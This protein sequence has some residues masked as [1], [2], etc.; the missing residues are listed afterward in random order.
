MQK[1]H[2][3][4]LV[5]AFLIL[6][7]SAWAACRDHDLEGTYD[8][9]AESSGA[10]GTVTTTCEIAV[11]RNG[12]VQGGA[13]CKL[14]NYGVEAVARVDGGEISISRSCRVTGQIVFDGYP[15]VITKARMS[16]DKNRVTGAGTNA[17]D[18]SPLTFTAT[19][20][21]AVKSKNPQRSGK[22]K[23]RWWRWFLH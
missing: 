21:V 5:V 17:L 16:R 14:S 15:S 4:A 6:P 20:Q 7:T 18:G 8:L 13:D 19:R 12:T 3:T 9:K 22:R 2:A 10:F 23:K 11:T 1:I